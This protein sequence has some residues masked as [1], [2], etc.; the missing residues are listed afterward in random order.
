YVFT[1]A[2]QTC[3]PNVRIRDNGI[4][5]L[6]NSSITSLTLPEQV[7]ALCEQTEI[8]CSGV[9]YNL[10]MRKVPIPIL[11]ITLTPDWKLL[12]T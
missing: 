4:F 5:P 11:F 12:H 2:N 7:L 10:G 1:D 6:N 8:V 9:L 3:R